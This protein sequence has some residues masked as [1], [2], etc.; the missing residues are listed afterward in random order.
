[1]RREYVRRDN[2]GSLQDRR[3]SPHR[4]TAALSAKRHR[5]P[6]RLLLRHRASALSAS[7]FP[8]R[9]RPARRRPANPFA[10]ATIRSSPRALRRRRPARFA[11]RAFRHIDRSP[12]PAVRPA[13]KSHRR[14][15][16]R[17]IRRDR[18]R[19][20]DRACAADPAAALRA[21]RG[22]FARRRN[23]ARLFG[24][25][26]AP[27]RASRPKHPARDD[28]CRYRRRSP[29]GCNPWSRCAAPRLCSAGR[30]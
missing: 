15:G 29:R 8:F 3:R 23:L 27:S 6:R 13:P 18:E 11:R 17:R 1:M 19:R 2:R 14:H 24:R 12:A 25:P 7:R 20:T 26:A 9:T 28:S 22:R 10:A 4:A 21:L 16:R 30:R 5:S